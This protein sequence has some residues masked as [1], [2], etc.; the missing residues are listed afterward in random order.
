MSLKKLRNNAKIREV[1]IIMIQFCKIDSNIW[2]VIEL[3]V[4][5]EQKCF[6][7]TNTES[8][9]EA[10][11]T[12]TSGNVALPFAIYN[13]ETLVGF[14]MFGYGSI[15]DDEPSVAES[16]YTIWRFRG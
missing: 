4:N 10:Y 9:L 12:I 13:D 14:V 16:N 3:S 11:V 6:V 7:A 1:N 8:I 2:K 5:D 15:G